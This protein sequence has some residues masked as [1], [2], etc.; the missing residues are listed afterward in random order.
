MEWGGY[1]SDDGSGGHD[2]DDDLWNADEGTAGS[3]AIPP[4]NVANDG[5]NVEDDDDDEEEEEEEKEE[6]EDE[7]DDDEEE[8]EEEENGDDD[9]DSNHACNDDDED[10]LEFCRSF[11]GIVTTSLR[12]QSF[13]FYFEVEVVDIAVDE[14]GNQMPIRF[15]VCASNPK[16]N[17]EPAWQNYFGSLSGKKWTSDEALTWAVDGSRQRKWH[18]NKGDAQGSWENFGSKWT[19]GNIIGFELDMRSSGASILRVSVNGS[20]DAPNGVAFA[21]ISAQPLEAFAA[22]DGGCFRINWGER[23]FTHT[24]PGFDVSG[25]NHASVSLWQSL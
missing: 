6:Q 23:P 12:L 16:W 21:D 2:D 17:L 10:L 25:T 8:E 4:V 9:D 3:G 22:G 1:D 14:H 19:A 7:E 18:T 11:N 24:P 5:G 15:G 13:K 20:F